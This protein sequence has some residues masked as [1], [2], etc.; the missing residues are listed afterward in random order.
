MRALQYRIIGSAP[1]VVDIPTPTPAAG[2]V[3]VKVTAAGVC[4]SDEFLM[5]LP[6]D[7]YTYGLPL[8]LGHEGA[9]TVEALGEGVTGLQIGESVL[10]Y[11]PWGCGRCYPCSKG[12]ENYCERAANLEIKPPGLGAPGAMADYLIVDDARHL[13]P[14]GDLDPVASV[15]LTDA[16][17]TPYHAIKKSLPKLVPGSV[18]VVIGAGGLGHVAIQILRAIAPCTVIAVDTSEDKRALARKV[19]AHHAV[20]SDESAE[21]QILE[22]TGGR[23][24]DVVFDFVSIDPTTGLASRLIGVGGEIVLVGVGPGAVKV[25][26]FSTPWE[27]SARAPYWGSRSELIEVIEL[28]RA[29]KIKV[30]VE[31]F[32]LDQ[33]PKAYER[34]AAGTIPGRAVIVP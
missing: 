25:G 28:A 16:G 17:L 10:V 19:G 5:S 26:F 21:E 9:G 32:G 15:P 11:G 6:D 18:A 4:H 7:Q 12:E 29:G 1:E 31:A 8:T 30:E 34:L 24:V 14:L 3:L 2:Q 20:A 13:V 23:K 22:L 33:G 27:A